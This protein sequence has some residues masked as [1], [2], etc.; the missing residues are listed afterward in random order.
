MRTLDRRS[1]IVVGSAS[2]LLLL[3]CVATILVGLKPI[4]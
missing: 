2:M 1:L 3:T 4:L